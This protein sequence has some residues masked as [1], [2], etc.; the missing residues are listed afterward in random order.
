MS[1][2]V[3]IAAKNLEAKKETIQTQKGGISQPANSPADRILFLQRTIG[4]KAVQRLA[5]S[6]RLQTK[7]RIGSPGD[8][9]EQ[10]ADRIAEQVMRMPEQGALIQRK[11]PKCMKGKDRGKIL[12]AKG[13]R[14]EAPE[15]PPSIESGINALKDGGKPLPLST[16]DFYKP[17]FDHDFSQVRIHTGP[18]AA[19]LTNALGAYAFT[20]ANDIFFN[21]GTYNPN[22]SEGQKLLAHELTHTLQQQGAASSSIQRRLVISPT[23]GIPLP[24]GTEGPPTP[25]TYAVSGL[26][27]DTCPDGNFQ[28]DSSTGV[29]S[30]GRATFCQWHPPL[31][32][33]KLEAD[34]SS[35]P[36]GCRCICDIVNSAQTTNIDFRTGAPE[37]RPEMRGGRPVGLAGTGTGNPTVRIDPRFQGQYLIGGRWVDIPFHLIFSHELCGHALPLMGGSHVAPGPGPRGGTPPHERQAVDVERA[38]AA[39]HSP[40]LPRRPE[41]YAGSARERP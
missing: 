14:S 3:R 40:P 5:R 34:A 22:T 7:L 17:R 9:Y 10:E 23:A 31:L 39:E 18:Q 33:D 1:E 11:C 37:T 32:P 38:I 36:A 24:A 41:D 2:K 21:T 4:N 13:I 28:V 27:R 29:V 19:M 8:K 20:T 6:G 30:S 26:L 35:T 25:L 12:R 16:R 15:A